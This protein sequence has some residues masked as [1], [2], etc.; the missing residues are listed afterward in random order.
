MLSPISSAEKEQVASTHKAG[1]SSLPS[2]TKVFS[3]V[4]DK[5]LSRLLLKEKIESS[6][7]SG[8]TTICHGAF[9]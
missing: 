2:G 6:N 7:L 4:V 9:V 8:L 5:R 1:S 3:E